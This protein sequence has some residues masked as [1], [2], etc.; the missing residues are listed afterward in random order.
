MTIYPQNLPRMF[1]CITIAAIYHPPHAN[2]RDLQSHVLHCIDHI[3]QR[4]PDSGFH[5]TGDFNQ[6]PDSYIT[7]SCSMKQIVTVPTR[8]DNTL[9]KIYTNMHML[10]LQP[11][12]APPLGTSDHDVVTCEPAV[13]SSFYTGHKIEVTTRVMG[14]NERAMFAMELCSVDWTPMYHLPSYT[15][16]HVF[17]YETLHDLVEK[18]F[19]HKIVIRH[20][21]E[22]PWITDTFRYSVRRRQVA[23]KQKDEIMFR[24]YRNKVNRMS[25]YLRSQFYHNKVADLKDVNPAQWWREVKKLTSSTPTKPTSRLQY[26]ADNNSPG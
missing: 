12:T 3:R 18:H 21:G 5:I 13:S 19:P 17:F 20:T 26:M 24:V 7:R 8:G 10:Y 6:F 11:E 14:K 22:K 16:Q 9:D 4:H 2:H 23:F 25:K 15:E 1:S